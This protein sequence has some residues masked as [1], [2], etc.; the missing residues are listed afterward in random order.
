MTS[1]GPSTHA[2]QSVV[3]DQFRLAFPTSVEPLLEMGPEFLTEA[4]HAAG[5][6]AP[7]NRVVS[8]AKS[9]EFFGGG[10]GRKLLL[11]LAY[12]RAE[13]GLHAE[14]FA[15]FPR[16]FGDPLRELF[17]PLME[18]EVRFALLSRR[19]GFPITV[20]KCY[21]ADY[22]SATK[23]GLLITERIGYGSGSIEP[24]QDKCLDYELEEPLGHYRALTRAIAR[25]AGSHRAGVFG[26]E[27]D[28]QFPF[29]P[30]K[31]DI[32]A[33]I[34]YTPEQLRQKLDKLR[35][36]AAQ[37]PRL[38]PGAVGSPDF[39][40]RFAAEAPL[41]LEHELEIRKYLNHASDCIALCHWNLNLD[42]A[43]FWREGGELHAGLLDWGS[44]AQM[45]VAQSFYGM[46]C[47]AE[48]PFLER[49]ER[50]L[51][52]LFI[53]VYRASGGPRLEFQEF[54]S[55]VKLSIALL[56]IA[57]ILD[58]PTLVEAQ[59]PG[60]REVKDRFDPTLRNDF[61]A[62]CQ[63]QLLIVML[64]EWRVHDVGRALADFAKTH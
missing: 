60:I 52:E 42:N 39:L 45:N 12:A 27:I 47:A 23:T 1:N 44:V 62:R 17:G 55:M 57:W 19:A 9:K 40:K 51:M 10:M 58:A 61:L 63:L 49:H 3:G 48:A 36:F 41:V 53:E 21:F 56:G 25:L 20:P 8:V 37:N 30:D 5:T 59:I 38:F 29:V 54:A 32:G 15:K 35:S 22:D 46:T 31:I 28:R 11:S 7:D 50:E 64:N 18:P 2:P 14:L 43:W 33:R 16:N 13:P 26:A 34:P 4:F 24:F 6:L